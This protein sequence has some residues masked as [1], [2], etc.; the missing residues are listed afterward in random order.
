MQDFLRRIARH[1]D[2]PLQLASFLSMLIIH[3]F[4]TSNRIYEELGT[5]ECRQLAFRLRKAVPDLTLHSRRF[6][7]YWLEPAER[8]ALATKFNKP[9]KVSKV[10][11]KG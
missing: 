9:A 1:Y 4:V 2:I 8:T 6:V 3:E 7:G 11:L 10:V 5:T